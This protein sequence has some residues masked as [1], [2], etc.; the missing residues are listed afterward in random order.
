M[1][2]QGNFEAKTGIIAPKAYAK[3]TRVDT[4]YMTKRGSVTVEI[5]YDV[6]ARKAD[7]A[8]IGARTYFYSSSLNPDGTIND[9]F[10]PIFYP[11]GNIVKNIYNDIKK[12]SEFRDWIDA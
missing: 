12:K 5:F 2:L 8:S 7:K 3:V 4:N 1:A 6:N 11:K 9:E 10:T